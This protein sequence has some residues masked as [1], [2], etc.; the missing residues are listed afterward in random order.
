MKKSHEKA[1]SKDKGFERGPFPG[2][3]SNIPAGG[4]S[5]GGHQWLPLALGGYWQITRGVVR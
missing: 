5:V 1:I 2:N 4:K 3:W